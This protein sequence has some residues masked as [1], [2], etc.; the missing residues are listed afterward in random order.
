M[1]SVAWKLSLGVLRLRL[2][3]VRLERVA[4]QIIPR[5]S[6]GNFRSIVPAWD[7]S[8][9]NF[10]LGSFAWIF[11]FRASAAWELEIRNFRLE[12][13]AL[14]FQFG[15]LRLGTSLGASRLGSEA[16]LGGVRSR[17]AA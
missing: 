6:F 13:F 16:Q 9:E 5:T 10:H 12:Y 14:E 11:S 2:R 1:G 17:T 7:L 8:P 15:I 4:L 3:S